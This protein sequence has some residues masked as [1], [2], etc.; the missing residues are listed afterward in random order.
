[1]AKLI[2]S[3]T[4]QFPLA[5]EFSF[6]VAD[7]MLN[8][9]GALDNFSAVS[10]HVFECIPLPVGA[11]V[12]SG[13]VVTDTAIT[14]STTYSVKVGDS[15][16]DARYLGATDKTA[17]GLTALVPTGLVGSGENIRITVTPTVAAATA[18]KVTVRVM[19]TVANRMSEVQIA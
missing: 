6:S 5:A 11:P 7:T 2:A 14:G 12:L 9:A 1:M 16:N 8:V 3:R 17:A 4:A 13:S 18:G 19:Y 15:V 10:A